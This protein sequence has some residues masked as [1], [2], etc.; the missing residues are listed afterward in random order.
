M[1]GTGQPHIGLN[2]GKGRV[3]V[4]WTRPL[5][6]HPSS[7]CMGVGFF[8]TTPIKRQSPGLGPGFVN[9]LNAPF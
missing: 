7:C 4:K 1:K 8:S 6:G 5:N 3:P 2:H 9:N